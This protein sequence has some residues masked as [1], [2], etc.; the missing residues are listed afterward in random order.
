[1]IET[2]HLDIKGMYCSACSGRIEKSV[3]KLDGVFDVNVNLATERGRVVFESESINKITILDRIN[4]LGYIP[5][6]I[7]QKGMKDNKKDA[8]IN[9]L[10]WKVIFSI[11]FAF[12][13]V[14]T[15]FVQADWIKVNL[16]NLFFSPWF[17]L[18]L[19]TPVQFLIAFPF[20]EGAWNAIRN[21]GSTMDVLVVISTTSAYFYSHYLTIRSLNMDYESNP[22]HLHFET[23]VLI[24]T[25][26]LVGKLMEAKTKRKTLD[27]ID[28]LNKLRVNTA[29]IIQNGNEVRKTIKDITPGEIILSKP[30][31][32]IPI[33]GEVI[34]GQTTINESMI[35]GESIPVEKKYGDI[36]YAGT[37][38][39]NSVIQIKVN[40][41]HSETVLSKIIDIVQDAQLSKPPI[42]QIA[43]RFTAYFVPIVLLLGF[44]TYLLWYYVLAPGMVSEALEKTIAVL[45][46][47]C[48]CA[49]GLATPMSIMVGSGQAAKLG[50]LIKEGKMIELL[51]K[52]N[53]VVLDKTGTITKGKPQVTDILVRNVDQTLFLQ[54]VGS[55]EKGANHPVGD[56]IAE[57][58][59]RI[60]PDI[61]MAQWIEVMF[62]YGV[63][64][65][66]MN[67][68][69]KVANVHYF[70]KQ[71]KSKLNPYLE[72]VKK[73]EQEG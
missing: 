42:Q 18:A 53:I 69:I 2:I 5:S 4:K 58:I 62:G 67:K 25:F 55:I 7:T 61:P 56:S 10:T 44:M 17:Q 49:L 32:R 48:P 22:I 40:K 6:V 30:G 60:I 19:A 31:E 46:I 73:L 34:A 35:S 71:Q 1:M 16:P 63:Q 36:V 59:E 13:L 21:K 9:H 45:I 15:M 65:V 3:L 23:S 47:S 24:I 38:N 20:Y 12:P 11:L 27:A 70:K 33:D 29:I 14:L 43:D 26:V 41:K 28:S 51:S 66:V 8:E 54:L 57:A 52:N 39:L 72:Q 37:I 68:T 64:G 50:I